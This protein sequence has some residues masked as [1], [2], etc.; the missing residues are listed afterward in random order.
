[1]NSTPR[2]ECLRKEILSLDLIASGTISERT[3]V[4]GKPNCRCA[5]D[6]AD[7]HGPYYEWTR[8]ENGRYVHSVVSPE[9]AKQLSAAIKNYRKIQSLLERWSKE[10]ARLIKM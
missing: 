4:C 10:S 1:M 2:I 6:P 9:K 7:R 5:K 3:K 8:R